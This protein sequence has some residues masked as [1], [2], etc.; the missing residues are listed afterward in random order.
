MT[1]MLYVDILKVSFD[2]QEGLE[3]PYGALEPKRG[4]EFD[5]CG[6]NGDYTTEVVCKLSTP[7]YI[8]Y[9]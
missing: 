1:V 7:T 6:I 3:K 5:C 9:I 2:T 4:R 8:I